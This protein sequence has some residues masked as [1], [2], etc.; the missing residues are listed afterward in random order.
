M[1]RSRVPFALVVVTAIATGLVTLLPAG[2]ARAFKPYTHTVVGD[3]AWSDVVDDGRVTI[4]E[5]SYAVR[6]KIVDAL[7]AWPTY[8]RAGTIGPDGFPDLTFGQSVIHP[9]QTGAWLRY[10]LRS[11]WSAQG[12]SSYTAAEKG[13]I[14]AFTYGF[15]THAAGDV[16]AHTLINDFAQG[17]FPEA[18]EILT[19][20]PKAAIALR[21]II[22]EGYVGDA[23]PGFDGNP[24]RTT[25]PNGDVS[26]DSTPARGLDAPVRWLYR[27]LVD[28]RVSLPTGSC[29]NGRDDD[30]DGLA[31]D[32]CYGSAPFTRGEPEQLRGPLI[33]YFLD[34]QSDLQLKRALLKA[35]MDHA[36]CALVDPD[37]YKRVRT[38]RID[39]VRG[40]REG[41]LTVQA[42]I[43][44]RFGCLRSP[45][46]IADDKLLSKAWMAY[47]EN[48]IDDIE[49]GLRAWGELGL[50]TTRGLFDP[51]ARRDLQNEKCKADPEST[52]ARARCE[53][54]VGIVDVV[55]HQARPFITGH[56]LSMLGAPDATGKVLDAL[57]ALSDLI[58]SLLPYNPLRVPLAELEKR[59][60]DLI[61]RE[62]RDVVGIDLATLDHML[63][64]PSVWMET[65]QIQLDLG[66]QL[67]VRKVN[68]FPAGTRQRLDRILGL[69]EADRRTTTVPMPDGSSRTVGVL[70]DT[71]VMRNAA[72]FDNAVV[73]S[74]LLLLDANGLN[75]VITDSLV[76]LGVMKDG[77]FARVY[78]DGSATPANVMVDGLNGGEPWLSLI[79]GDH[80]WR[81]DGKPVFTGGAGHGG[82]GN[83]PLW[84]SCLVRPAFG[85]TLF[86]DWENG[87]AA[88][89]ALDD[90]T[91]SDGADPAA[92]TSSLTVAAPSYLRKGKKMSEA[93]RFLGVGR[94]EFRASDA[95]FSDTTVQ[96]RV[97]WKRLE[98]F[99]QRF[100]GSYG[101]IPLTDTDGVDDGY[102]S[103]SQRVGDPCH[104]LEHRKSL[105][106]TLD[107]RDP[108]VT[109]SAPAEGLVVDSASKIPVSW[110]LVDPGG[111]K[112]ASGIN[113]DETVAMVGEKTVTDGGVLSTYRLYPGGHSLEV[114]GVDNVQNTGGGFTIFEV[115]ATAASLVINVDQGDHNRSFLD[116]EVR[117]ALKGLLM[118]AAGHHAAG[119]HAA[120]GDALYQARQLLLDERETSVRPGYA[121]YMVALIEELITRHIPS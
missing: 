110:S 100:F 25:L 49:S 28:P 50:A 56:L 70:S 74:K 10:L 18:K 11:A 30:E 1:S 97:L 40:T 47:L 24:D 45:T 109:I 6:P 112:L 111:F 31:D 81:Q 37:C 101:E 78:Q 9:D 34:L 13:Q 64:N 77:A 102:R 114:E 8:Y 90:E 7:R 89:P 51:Q 103:V 113:E 117:D 42:C 58:D 44:A 39:T 55:L 3:S 4:G 106:F 85:G 84:E 26:D 52:E 62:I 121:D 48:W 68:L 98:G 69:T 115:Q 82:N 19:S 67:G 12:D 63:K 43:G 92:P 119:D 116:D 38:V 23:T 107:T 94:L 14:L 96:Q 2:T 79:D 118:S 16:W 46:D 35:D 66:P 5:L 88:F 105:T 27:T 53:A 36:N 61:L 59:G 72:P 41:K 71:A 120:E 108:V 21:H 99:S 73:L 57:K 87:T 75:R 32:G 83:F 20:V 17:V 22:V 60:K 33:D 29:G 91:R 54:K 80:A 15:L 86:R 65:E 104:P 76:G 95:I 93:V